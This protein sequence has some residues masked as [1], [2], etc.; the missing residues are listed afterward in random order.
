M[1]CGKGGN[2]F[3]SLFQFQFETL[4]KH[5]L[6]VGDIVMV[7]EDNRWT[8]RRFRKSGEVKSF[9]ILVITS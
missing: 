2:T 9:F 4:S 7:L 6:V 1:N 8:L 5:R 3:H